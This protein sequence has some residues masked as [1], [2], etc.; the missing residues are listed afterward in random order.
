[1]PMVDAVA[2]TDLASC[3]A[4]EQPDV[5]CTSVALVNAGNILHQALATDIAMLESSAIQMVVRPFQNGCLSQR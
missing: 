5:V 3:L 1:M 2:R 4:A